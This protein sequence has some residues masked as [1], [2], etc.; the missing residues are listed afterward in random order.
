MIQTLILVFPPLL[1]GRIRPWNLHMY[2]YSGDWNPYCMTV[3]YSNTLTFKPFLRPAHIQ[4]MWWLP[5]HLSLTIANET[6]N[7]S[8]T[9]FSS[10]GWRAIH[11]SLSSICCLNAYWSDGIYS[12]ILNQSSTS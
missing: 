5:L 10:L 12:Q 11:T 3:T 8:D 9:L 6:I 1:L 7:F 4:T 2:V